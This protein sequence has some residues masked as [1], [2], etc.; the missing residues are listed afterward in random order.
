MKLMATITVI[1][2]ALLM[3]CKEPFQK[4]PGKLLVVSTTG[5]IGDVVGQIGGS[6]IQSESLMGPGVD[7]HLYKPSQGDINLLMK[8]DL[9]I[10]NGYHLEGKLS[11]LLKKV[12]RTKEVY[13]AAELLHFNELILSD[14]EKNIPDP[15][16]WL[17]VNL[18][19]KVVQGIADKI[20]TT[21]PDNETVYQANAQEYLAALRHLDEELQTLAS[22]I[23]ATNRVLVTAHDAFQY[24]GRAYDLEV[25][26]VQGISTLA[27]PGIR[28]ISTMVEF[29]IQNEIKAVFL[30]ASIPDK[31]LRSI[32]AGC[33]ARGYMVKLDGNLYSDSLGSRIEGTDTYIGMMQ[34][35]MKLI[36]QTL[37]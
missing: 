1:I 17:D 33:R 25:R 11:G 14:H 2:L 34:H 16:I 27:E 13:A 7:P 10:Y 24:F 5:I 23:P 29:I 37:Q 32:V 20:I 9:I 3:G 6:L 15:H 35:N 4:E 22:Q 31:I 8:A 28:D 18:W 30:E 26:G 36:S 21:D 19:I 12:S